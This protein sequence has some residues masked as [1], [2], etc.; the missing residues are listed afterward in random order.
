MRKGDNGLRRGNSPQAKGRCRVSQ[1]GQRLG[2]K[3]TTST[4]Q[5]PT[6]PKPSGCGRA[7]PDWRASLA[8][9]LA[10]GPS[11]KHRNGSQAL[12]HAKRAC[13]LSKFKHFRMLDVLAAA[14]AQDGQ[15]HLAVET[16]KQ[17]IALIPGGSN[18]KDRGE[19]EERLRLYEIKRPYRVNRSD[20]GVRGN[21]SN[22]KDRSPPRRTW[23]RQGG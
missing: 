9:L 4:K 14:Y 12:E 3:S 2:D 8:W 16:E 22:L 10:T 11:E 5:S 23:R 15:F 18:G 6:T 1:S 13:E 17:A 19:F 7:R 20:P 21:D